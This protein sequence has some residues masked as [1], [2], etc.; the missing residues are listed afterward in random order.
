MIMTAE[1]GDHPWDTIP[2]N[3]APESVQVCSEPGF[4]LLLVFDGLEES[5]QVVGKC[6][7]RD[8]ISDQ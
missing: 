1:K 3:S 5:N 6:E 2:G 4:H 8:D 7:E